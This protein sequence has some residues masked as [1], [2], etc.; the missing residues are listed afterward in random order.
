MSKLTA[1]AKAELEHLIKQI[2]EEVMGTI[3]HASFEGS[4]SI[5]DAVAQTTLFNL[6]GKGLRVK[7]KRSASVSEKRK[8]KDTKNKKT[9]VKIQALRSNLYSND[10]EQAIV[11]P[12]AGQTINPISLMA[13]LNAK[14]GA[15]IIENMGY[16]GLENR[17]GTF[18]GSVRV[19]DVSFTKQGFP[20]I[21]YTYQANPYQVF[22]TGGRGKAPWASNDRD[23]RRLIDRSIRE[24]A[25][26]HLTG[27]FYTRRM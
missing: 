14:I 19:L 16:P 23:P 13:I 8:V 3:D 21:G 15:K 6:Q 25:A 5:K 24:I 26:E 9:N 1:T 20:S 27:R 11:K 10:I 2:V 4:T 12:K 7:G 17:S 18:A 22:E